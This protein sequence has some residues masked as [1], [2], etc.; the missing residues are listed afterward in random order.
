MYYSTEDLQLKRMQKVN[1]WFFSPPDLNVFI[2]P[3]KVNVKLRLN[4]LISFKNILL[5]NTWKKLSERPF[6]SDIFY[7]NNW[8]LKS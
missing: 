2:I 8:I 1:P 5:Q 7:L 6:I 3:I 4:Y